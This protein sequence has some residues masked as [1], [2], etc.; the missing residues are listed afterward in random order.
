MM[1]NEFENEIITYSHF[2]DTYG[3]LH[4]LMYFHPKLRELLQGFFEN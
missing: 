1:K 4:P 3:R 2:P